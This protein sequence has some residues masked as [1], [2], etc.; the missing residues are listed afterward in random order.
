MVNDSVAYIK[1]LAARHGRNA[2]WAEKAVREAVSLTAEEAL[3]QGVIDL[4]AA[5]IGEL[6]E[7]INGRTVVMESGTRQLATGNVQIVRMDP[8]WRTRLLAM[9]TDP[10]IAYILML[11]GIYGLIYELANP[12]FFLPGVAGAICI[13]LALYTFHVL[14]INYAGLA[15]IALGISFMVAEA[16]VPSIGALG[17]GG[18]VAFVVGSIILMDEES[19]RISLSL[20]L[21]TAVCSAGFFLWLIRRLYTVSRRKVLTGSEEMIGSIGEAM[22]DFSGEGRIWIHGES[23]RATVPSEVKKGQKVKVVSQEGLLLNGKLV[24]EDVI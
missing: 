6:L 8:D 3:D 7:K 12:G 2:E 24:Q 16:F 5:N 14:P 10:N 18:V 23:W 4:I 9:I 17:I 20:I 15:L 13:L 22:E 1:A 21:V 19:M 11:M